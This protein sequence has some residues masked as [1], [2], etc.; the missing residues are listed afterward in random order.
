MNAISKW[1]VAAAGAVVMLVGSTSCSTVDPR[2]QAML[3]ARA[4]R[5]AAEPR[6]D[7]FIGRRYWV[8]RTQFWGYLRRPGQSWDKA[9]LVMMNENQQ[10]TPDH[11]GAVSFGFDTNHEYRIWGNFTGDQVYDPNSNLFLPEFMLSRY[12]LISAN[13]GFLFDP[14]ERRSVMSLPSMR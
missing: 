1:M 12:E 9:R 2:T 14:N 3:E 5:I 10:R 11:T 4:S 8:M 6:G 13:P 7:Y